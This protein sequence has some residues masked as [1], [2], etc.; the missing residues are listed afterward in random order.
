MLRHFFTCRE[1][2]LVFGGNTLV[3]PAMVEHRTAHLY[4]PGSNPTRCWLVAN[5][6]SLD[7][8]IAKETSLLVEWG[9]KAVIIL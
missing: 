9:S 2:G 7:K 8:Q 3:K 4:D 1:I 6:K 5:G